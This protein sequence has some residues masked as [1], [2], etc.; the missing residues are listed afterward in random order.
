MDSALIRRQG[1]GDLDPIVCDLERRSRD[2]A[3]EMGT[4]LV[5]MVTHSKRGPGARTSFPD[6]VINPLGFLMV[7]KVIGQG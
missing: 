5:A 3:A 7:F 6:V 1:G 2:E 4:R